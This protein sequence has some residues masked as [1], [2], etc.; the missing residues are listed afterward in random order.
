MNKDIIIRDIAKDFTRS[1]DKYVRPTNGWQEFKGKLEFELT[2]FNDQTD[3]LVFLY[4]VHNT[5]TK[6]LEN[7]IPKCPLRENPENC[8]ID[9]FCSRAISFIEQEIS[10]LNPD[11]KFIFLHPNLNSELLRENLL[12]LKDFPDSAK[13]Y[14][15]A[16]N[17]LNEQRH[18]RNLLDDLRLSLEL[19][20]QRILSNDKSLENQIEKI[21]TFLKNRGASTE[22]RNMFIT[23]IN[24]YSKYQN[25][26][27]KH[28][29]LVKQ[30]EIEL[31]VN[32]TG[33]FISFL[34]KK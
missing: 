13:L 31:I 7:H 10:I 32:L 20:L 11:F 1:I 21:G 24:Y 4:E 30:N 19:L 17:K 29:D 27:V 9:S 26:Y 16:L 18:E 33:A 34:I 25:N 6:I 5:V 8:V 14:Q 15:S 22:L 23:I 2:N 3:K 28:N 12:I